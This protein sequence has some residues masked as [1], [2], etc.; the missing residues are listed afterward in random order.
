M[1]AAASS[2]AELAPR[3]RLAEHVAKAA[4]RGLTSRPKHLPPWLF[5][6]EEGSRLFEAITALEEYYLTRTERSILAGNAA[7]MLETAAAG[8]RLRIQE[9]G[10]GSADKTRLLL[11]AA[12]E[13]QGPVVYEPIDVSASALDG[14]RERIEREIPGVHVIPRVMDYT[15]GRALKLDAC[16]GVRRLVVYIGSSIGNFEPEEAEQL[17][18][19]VRAG[20]APGDALL[21][22][23]DLV[24]D[25]ETLL[26]AYDDAEGVTAAF[27]RNMLVRLNRE[28]GADFN[29]RSFLHRALWNPMASRIEMH[30]ESGMAQ[31][32]RLEGLRLE[33]GF[34]EGETI[35]TENSYKYEPGQA[36][37]LLCATGFVPAGCWTDAREWF[38]V[39][40]GRAK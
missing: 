16:H 20:L 37:R 21:L 23:V 7:E 35:H 17:L 24:K 40:L 1:S 33:I 5:Y 36:E 34:E 26:A 4:Y 30:L 11:Q 15:H 27:N 38:A 32:V 22:G 39:H 2:P 3:A 19:R 13:R 8:A 28:L 31:R 29:P 25:E 14:G 6:D 9:L 12:V 18:R 10:A